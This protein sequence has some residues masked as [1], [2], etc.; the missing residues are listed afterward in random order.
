MHPGAAIRLQGAAISTAIRT[1][2]H[3]MLLNEQNAHVH[4][5]FR[6]ALTY[7]TAYAHLTGEEL[8]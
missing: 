5:V 1:S 2:S 4:F 3:P 7:S 8:F 6:I